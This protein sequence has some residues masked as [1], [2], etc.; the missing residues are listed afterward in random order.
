MDGKQTQYA[1]SRDKYLVPFLE[2]T[3]GLVSKHSRK[4]GCSENEVRIMDSAEREVTGLAEQNPA[5][6]PTHKQIYR[7][8]GKFTVWLTEQVA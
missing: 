6:H 2:R 8:R 3:F 4:T 1:E 5:T 7:G